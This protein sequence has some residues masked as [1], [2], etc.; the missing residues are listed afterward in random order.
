MRFLP[1]ALVCVSCASGPSARGAPAEN[2]EADARAAAEQYL[3]AVSGK[4]AESGLDLLLGGATTNARL[5]SLDNWE[6][7][8]V[9]PARHEDGDVAAVAQAVDAVDVASRDALAGLV[10]TATGAEDGSAVQ[11]LSPQEAQQV[12]APTQA[13][14]DRLKAAHPLIASVLRVGQPVFFHPKNPARP[15]LTGSGAYALDVRGYEIESKEGPRK[16]A[17]RWKLAV[18]RFTS[19]TVDTGWKVLPAADWNAE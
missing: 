12:M 19:A 4:G 10:G 6:I 9:E 3:N 16:V 11:Q 13:S 2:A 7:V 1:V 8:S 14:A 18:V 15:L 5:F 17:R